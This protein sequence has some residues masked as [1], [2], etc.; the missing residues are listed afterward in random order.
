[1]RDPFII[2]S[3]LTIFF[4]MLGKMPLASACAIIATLSVFKWRNIFYVIYIKAYNIHVDIYNY[5][6][7]K[8][9]ALFGGEK[10]YEEVEACSIHFPIENL[11]KEYATMTPTELLNKKHN[12]LTR[13]LAWA[14]AYQ[15]GKKADVNE[16]FKIKAFYPLNKNKELVLQ[17]NALSTFAKI[18]LA[19]IVNERIKMDKQMQINGLEAKE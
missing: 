18:V 17:V 14:V 2:F 15:F 7:D 11:E 13:D 4:A 5:I 16:H 1:M 3:V 10:K 8:A 19:I 9:L 12:D 6:Y